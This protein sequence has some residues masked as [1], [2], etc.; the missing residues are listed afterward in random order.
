MRKIN[1]QKDIDSRREI[2]RLAYRTERKSK[3]T[4]TNVEPTIQADD[5]SEKSKRQPAD[6]IHSPGAGQKKVRTRPSQRN[7]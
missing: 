2:S 4:E 6:E 7:L 3:V 5:K 1:I